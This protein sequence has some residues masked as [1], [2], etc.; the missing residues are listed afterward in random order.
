MLNTARLG[1]LGAALVCAQ[2]GAFGMGLVGG[3][4]WVSVGS[5]GEPVKKLQKSHFY[6]YTRFIVH[7]TDSARGS[8]LDLCLAFV[9]DKAGG[10]DELQARQWLIGWLRHQ[11]YVEVIIDAVLPERSFGYSF[12][13]LEVSS[14]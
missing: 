13:R 14:S 10:D 5:C 12:G 11:I 1:V 6:L 4:L 2:Y 8:N 9:R 7:P 3:R